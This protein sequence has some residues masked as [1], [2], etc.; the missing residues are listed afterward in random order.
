MRLLTL[1]V[2][3]ILLVVM[4]TP[5]EAASKVAVVDMAKIIREH[6]RHNVVEDAFRK[7]SQAAEDAAKAGRTELEAL[8]KKIDAMLDN[9]PGRPLREKQY[10]EK[11][12]RVKFN[13]EWARQVAVR[14]YA[15]GLESLYR[16]VRSQVMAY[17]KEQG[18]DLVLHETDPSLPMKP[19]NPDDYELKRLLRPVIYADARIN[20]TDQVLARVKA[21]R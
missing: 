8:K 14:E 20:I 6:P 11:L 15:R 4:A 7:A 1:I 13:F 9:E 10:Q 19:Q 3:L 16:A 21:Q 5:A 18:I 2:P 17:A 12:N